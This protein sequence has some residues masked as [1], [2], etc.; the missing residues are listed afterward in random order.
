MKKNGKKL[1]LTLIFAVLLFYPN[2]SQLITSGSEWKYLDD[3]SDQGTT[4]TD[5]NYDDSSWASGNAQLG[6]GDGDEATV[7]SYGSD[8][9]NKYIT[10]YFRKVINVSNP[11]EQNGLK[12]ELLRDDGAVVYL[13]GTEVFRSNMP[14]ESIT[15]QTL[16]AST[17][18]SD[19]EDVFKIKLIPSSYLVSGDNIIAVEVHQRSVTSSDLSFDFKL[20]F[21]FYPDF[22][23]KPYLIFINDNTKANILWQLRE[24]ESCNFK[25]GTDENYTS[26]DITTTEYGDDHQ[27]K[28]E[29]TD[30]DENT[31]YYYKVTGSGEEYTGSFITGKPDSEYNFSFYAYGDT[32]TYP[33]K[34]D[35]VAE[36]IM[37]EISNNPESQTFIVNSGDLVENG[38]DEN[39][40]DNQFFLGEY[41]NIINLL[42]NLPYA[43]AVG[44][45]EGAGA[46]FE[47][48][49]P[50]P[51]FSSSR[52]YYSFD[53]A[54]AHFTVIDEYTDFSSTSDQ[55][56][57]IVSDLQNTEKKWKFILMHKPGWSAGGHSNDINVQNILQPLFEQYGISV[58]I[59]GHNHYYARAVV[60]GI[61]HITTGGGGA[62]LYDPNPSYPNIVKT[63]KSYHFLKINVTEDSLYLSAIRSDGTLIEE[64]PVYEPTVDIQKTEQ[65]DDIKVICR[66]NKIIKIQNVNNVFGNIEIYD[67]AGKCVYKSKLNSIN[68]T[69]SLKSSGVFIVKFTDSENNIKTYKVSVY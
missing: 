21:D 54:N 22:R 10:Y 4:W 23:K 5:L 28:A 39:D 43:A 31:K 58:V 57:W 12:I 33:D 29:L 11:N 24:T 50:Y 8:A 61:H 32:R 60:N 48:Y 17:I 56:N 27:H 6:Y 62:P 41:V 18:A 36:Q 63:D 26:G 45:H 68:K 20:S 1:L 34:H 42:A 25:W 66:G 3:G 47:K 65:N 19:G 2:F 35:L 37:S 64:F 53:Y 44:N 15:Y 46:L 7:I 51:M 14:S 67:T 40:W 16:A 38:D 9:S 30:L 13:N 52:Y 59:T 55:Y 49:F 69:I